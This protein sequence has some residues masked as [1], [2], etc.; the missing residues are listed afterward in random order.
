MG[1]PK[2]KTNNPAGRPPGARGKRSEDL[3]TFIEGIINE[4]RRQ[5]REDLQNIEP[6]KRLA[7]LEKLLSY[8]LPKLQAVDTNVDFG[9][10]TDEQLDRI[11][12]ELKKIDHEN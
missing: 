3:R 5:L 7:I 2:G 12:H 6:E 11:I 4:N 8:V 9:K 1:L 10:L